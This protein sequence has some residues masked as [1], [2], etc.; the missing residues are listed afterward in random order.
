MELTLCQTVLAISTVLTNITWKVKLLKYLLK[1]YGLSIIP[2]GE[3][4][5]MDINVRTSYHTP[6]TDLKNRCLHMI[7]GH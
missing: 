5:F 2:V 4:Y 1:Y 3:H 6:S 7:Y